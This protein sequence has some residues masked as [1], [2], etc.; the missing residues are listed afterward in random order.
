MENP[1]QQ[2][3]RADLKLQTYKR[4]LKDLVPIGKAGP[5]IVVP[6]HHWLQ[7][8]KH[9][10][11]NGTE[12]VLTLSIV[13]ETSAQTVEEILPKETADLASDPYS[14][15]SDDEQSS[16]H[17]GNS[18]MSLSLV[19]NGKRAHE[20][21]GYD[22][23][24]KRANTASVPTKRT[25]HAMC[26]ISED[27]AV[28]IGG[29]TNSSDSDYRVH[30]GDSFYQLQL[31]KRQGVEEVLWTEVAVIN[32]NHQKRIGHQLFHDGQNGTVS[33]VGGFGYH[34]VATRKRNKREGCKNDDGKWKTLGTMLTLRVA[35]S[36]T[37]PDACSWE[38]HRI[39]GSVKQMAYYAAV[40]HQRQVV[41]F[42]GSTPVGKT[43][44]LM[45]ST[46]ITLIPAHGRS[47]KWS[48]S[49]P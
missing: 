21:T 10:V 35:S 4:T 28:M 26:A 29:E 8:E 41:T 18:D 25:G 15:Y 22:S 47:W 32:E 16:T 33:L 24:A 12:A 5:A 48:S 43:T 17:S 37:T 49:T 44:T 23:S 27:I 34:P 14:D 13:E 19:E 39:R 3:W 31:V 46:P 42:G 45:T 38:T 40:I 11:A 6:I 1:Y 7:E 36:G 9:K 20:S 30:N 2:S